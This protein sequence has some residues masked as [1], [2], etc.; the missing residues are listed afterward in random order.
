MEMRP[1]GDRMLLWS[2]GILG[3]VVVTALN[4]WLKTSLFL[5]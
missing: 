4:R 2:D 3:K 5:S 1:A